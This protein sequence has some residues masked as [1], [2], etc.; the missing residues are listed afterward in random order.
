MNDR[1]RCEVMFTA[2]IMHVIAVGGV[3]FQTPEQ[4]E[5]F[6]IT[7]LDAV[8]EP[9]RDLP[10]RKAEQIRRRVERM[11]HK[12]I[13][14]ACKNSFSEKLILVGYHFMNNLI[15]DEYLFIAE[16]SPLRR[17]TDTLLEAVDMENEVAQKRFKK[18]EKQARK[19]LETL[20][21]EGYF[22]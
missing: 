5:R 3:T 14:P 17:V 22:Q 16:D 8:L 9:V 10:V 4:H 21:G 6:M 20:R 18:A 1:Q 19:W 7:S 2:R 12:T 15:N 11:E 13:V